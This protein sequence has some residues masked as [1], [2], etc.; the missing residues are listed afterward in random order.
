MSCAGKHPQRQLR[1]PRWLEG[2]WRRRRDRGDVGHGRKSRRAH[3]SREA[4]RRAVAH[5]LDLDPDVEHSEPRA[6]H[7]GSRYERKADVPE[8]RN[9]RFGVATG[10]GVF[11]ATSLCLPQWSRG[12]A[13][14]L[15][16]TIDTGSGSC[17]EVLDIDFV[18]DDLAIVSD[19][20]CAEPGVVID[21]GFEHPSSVS[22]WFASTLPT[23]ASWSY[24][25]GAGAHS[26]NGYGTLNGDATCSYTT[27]DQ[28]MTVPDAK[29]GEGGPMLRFWY[30]AAGTNVEFLSSAG[31]LTAA[32]TWTQAKLCMDPKSAGRGFGF[33]IGFQSN[34]TGCVDPNVSVD[35]VEI[36]HDPSCPE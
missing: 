12:L 10:T 35:D 6:P 15:T 33:E 9:G 30:K 21:G 1:R 19:P 36:V 34:G 11:E 7:D 16:F 14:P 29:V 32:F 22:A 13:Q 26:G 20:L 27:L 18:F 24:G 28:Q 8:L 2:L 23:G 31:D 5:G 17:D 25:N 4:L 3:R